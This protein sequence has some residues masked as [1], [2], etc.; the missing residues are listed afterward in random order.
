MRRQKGF[1]LLEL[2][3]VVVIIAIIASIAVPSLLRSRAIADLKTCYGITA[4]PE[5]PQ[6]KA[7]VRPYMLN[8]LTE[9]EKAAEVACVVKAPAEAESAKD[10]AEVTRQMLEY[11]K[12]CRDA[13]WNLSVARRVYFED[14]A[15]GPKQ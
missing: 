9:Y 2:L 6:E 12:A 11:R 7:I 15:I 5:T 13:I 10:G 4:A 8:R 14:F 3:I 1:T